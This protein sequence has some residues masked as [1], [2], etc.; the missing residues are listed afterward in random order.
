MPEI[1][2]ERIRQLIE[3]SSIDVPASEEIKHMI[4]QISFEMYK[5]GWREAFKVVS[6]SV[7]RCE[8]IMK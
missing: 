8:E 7:E 6:K 4:T 2:R 3:D 1:V 5:A